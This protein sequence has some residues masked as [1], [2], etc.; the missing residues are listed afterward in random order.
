MQ[1]FKIMSL[2]GIVS[3]VGCAATGVEQ[4]ADTYTAAQV[5]T[6][7][8]AKIVQI[9][10]VG[11]AKV[12]VDNSQA[13]KQAEVGGAVAGALLGGIIGS[14]GGTSSTIGGGVVGGA[15]GG[16]AGSMVADKVLVDGVSLTYVFN[17]KT[18]NSA[19]VGRV[20]E[21]KEGKGL[22]ISTGKPNETRIQPNNPDGCPKDK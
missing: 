17:R 2:I 15:V 4:R 20:C 6:A 8:E 5:N 21:F 11:P 12:Q 7:Q 13:K 10:L 18:L 9:L 16:A 19:Q 3:L 22:M 14:K 1:I